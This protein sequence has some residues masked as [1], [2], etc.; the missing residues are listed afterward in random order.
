MESK[1]RKLLQVDEMIARLRLN[2]KDVIS[3]LQQ[4][5]KEAPP[6]QQLTDFKKDIFEY[7]KYF[8][9]SECSYFNRDVNLSSNIWHDLSYDSLDLVE[10]VVE[11]ERKY[12]ISIP[13]E[14]AENCQTVEDVV[15][16]V[17]N[18]INER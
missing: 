16:L 11:L 4:K 2:R 9:E 7:V 15:N 12:S 18:L 17:Y 13:D 6:E 5:E 1:N 14:M 3:F 10:L 8:F